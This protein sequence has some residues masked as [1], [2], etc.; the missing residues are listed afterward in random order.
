VKP[1]F[2]HCPQWAPRKINNFVAKVMLGY[3]KIGRKGKPGG[4]RRPGPALR[5]V[6]GAAGGKK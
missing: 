6:R 5:E 4:S 1:G 3:K 2:E